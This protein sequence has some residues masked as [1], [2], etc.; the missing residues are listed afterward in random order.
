[1][2]RD[3]D[4]AVA[5]G[6]FCRDPWLRALEQNEQ[7]TLGAGMFKRDSQKRL[8]ELAKDDLAGHRLRGFDDARYIEL[9]DRRANGC[10]ETIPRRSNQLRVKPIELVHFAVGAPAQITS[11][12]VP[13]IS[14]GSG[15]E[16]ARC[17]E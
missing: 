10:P 1:M 7:A 13:Q 11:P 5:N 16:A 6:R 12:G 8:D 14:V 3:L 17:V 2:Q 9:L 4:L 15:F